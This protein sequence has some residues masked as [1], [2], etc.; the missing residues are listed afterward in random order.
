MTSTIAPAAADLVDP[1]L[2]TFTTRSSLRPR[3]EGCNICTWIGFKHVNYLAEEAVLDHLRQRGFRAGELYERHGLCVDITSIDTRMRSA[4]HIDDTAEVTV[5]QVAGKGNGPEMRFAVDMAADRDG[6]AHT[7]TSKIGVVLRMDPKHGPAAP[8]PAELAPHVVG[9]LGHGGTSFTLDGR[10]PVQALTEGRNAYAWRWRVPYF[11]CHYTER[12]QA[13]G[14]L[15]LMEEAVDLFLADRGVSIKTLLDDQ[16]WI[17]VV[18]RSSVTL[19]GEAEME[20]EIFTVFTVEE[21]FKQLSYTARMDCYVRRGDRLVPTAT[22]R[23]THGYA[24]IDSRRD[25]SVVNLDD[26][27]L[28]ALRGDGRS[29]LLRQAR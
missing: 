13:S 10:D 15:R 19:L 9:R 12:L 23:I 25:W 22:G 26:R 21:V 4:Y 5:E 27:M 20:D 1:V 6:G 7:A 17:P 11:Y 24:V 2:D 8:P 18:P 14:Y 16:D 3:Y 29:G 28:T